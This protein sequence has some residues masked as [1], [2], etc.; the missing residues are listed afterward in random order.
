[1]R[2]CSPG[3]NFTPPAPD[4]SALFLF[5]TT[6]ALLVF[7]WP[8]WSAESRR[9]CPRRRVGR[10]GPGRQCTFSVFGCTF[11]PE[12]RRRGFRGGSPRRRGGTSGGGG[13]RLLALLLLAAGAGLALLRLRGLFLLL[14]LLVAVGRRLGTID[15]LQQ[16]HR[17][18]V[19]VPH[20]GLD[21]A[22][23]AALAV[24]EARGDRVEDPAHHLAVGHQR[25]HL[26]ARVEVLAL[27][28]RDDV[29]GQAAHGLGLGLGGLDAL[30]AEQPDQ[31]VA[32]E[33]PPVLRE[34]PEL[35]A[36]DAM[37]HEAPLTSPR[38]HGP[39]RRARSDRSACRATARGRP[40]R[41]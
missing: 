8:S 18:G 14:A 2:T 5:A 24:G 9:R 32:E 22:R 37:P 34:P 25:Q 23:V 7:I 4:R 31:Q 35:V 30:V 33:R 19:A 38:R 21:E 10:P 13:G 6:R 27:G 29:V 12:G 17:R 11:W 28:E 26:A 20:A 41:S 1:M 3:A 15:Q 39:A 40:A 16:H 36:V